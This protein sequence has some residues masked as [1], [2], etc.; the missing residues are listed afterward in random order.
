MP[1]FLNRL[2]V[3]VT[4]AISFWELTASIAIVEL[5]NANP[6]PALP[7]MM[8]IT[9]SQAGIPGNKKLVQTAPIRKRKEP[10][11]NVGVNR[12][13]QVMKNPVDTPA[14]VRA[15]EGAISRRPEEVG[16]SSFTAWKNRGAL[17]IIVLTTMLPSR[18]G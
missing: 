4:T 9:A 16:L 14:K 11:I 3:V 7:G 15:Q 6:W 8:K 17:K 13:V 18:E 1:R 5:G 10:S 12:R 2:K